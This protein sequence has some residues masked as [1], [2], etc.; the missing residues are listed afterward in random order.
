MDKEKK[1][2]LVIDIQEDYTGA[3][4]KPP[5]PYKDSENL[6]ATVNKITE[7]AAKKNITTVYIRQEFDGFFGRLISRVFGHSTAIK[8][9]PGTE[10]DKR[11]VIRSNHCF[12]KSMPNAFSNPDFESFLEDNQII[13]LYLVGLDAEGCVYLTAK[14]ALKRGYKVSIIKDG[15]VLLAEKKWDS[16]LK[17]YKKNGITLLLSKEFDEETS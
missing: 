2:L 14:G 9:S 12:A 8:G 15:I 4:A 6:I 16:L 17:K 7:I 3:T 11:I 13:E 1:A 5:F 10:F